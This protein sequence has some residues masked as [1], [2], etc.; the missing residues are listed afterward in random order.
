MDAARLI[1]RQVKEGDGLSSVGVRER[2][3][4]HVEGSHLRALVVQ[5]RLPPDE[6]LDSADHEMGGMS[7]R[8]VVPRRSRLQAIIDSAKRHRVRNGV[9]TVAGG[10]QVDREDRRLYQRLRDAVR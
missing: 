1:D 5:S 9:V 4:V 8:L 10:V 6:I 7:V 3:E 2:R